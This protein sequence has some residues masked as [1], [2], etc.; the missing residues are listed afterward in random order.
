MRF[1]FRFHLHAEVEA[2][3]FDARSQRPGDEADPHSSPLGRISVSALIGGWRC[4]CCIKPAY[5]DQLLECVKANNNNTVSTNR[6][7]LAEE[8]KRS[9]CWLQL[10]GAAQ[11]RAAIS[12]SRSKAW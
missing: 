10:T 5:G 4:G 9:L 6:H 12:N 1:R 11:L 2:V 7:L 3:W 8:V